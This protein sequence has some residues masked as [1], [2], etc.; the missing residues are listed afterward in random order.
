MS[1]TSDDL[2]A[3][4]AATL[5]VEDR[6]TLDI[7]ANQDDK[8]KILQ[9]LVELTE[10]KKDEC[11]K[12]RLKLKWPGK[13][14]EAIIL[15]DLYGKMV[16]WIQVF[17][18]VGDNA[19]QFDPVH[20]ALPW[21][22]VRFILQVHT[23]CQLGTLAIFKDSCS[24]AST[25]LS[26][27]FSIIVQ[28]TIGRLRSTTRRSLASWPKVSRCCLRQLAVTPFSRICIFAEPLKDQMT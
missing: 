17:I 28:L 13:K 27:I 5:S 20:A 8:R 19:I 21:A 26:E 16:K 25:T 7:D 18:A 6:Q 10:S 4:A 12:K 24:V 11:I 3:S 15:G 23:L 22:A 14:G 1:K 9:S 2:W